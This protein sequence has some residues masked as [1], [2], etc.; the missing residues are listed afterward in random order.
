MS[1]IGTLT[2]IK[3]CKI[4]GDKDEFF[5]QKSENV[6]C[7]LKHFT[8]DISKKHEFVRVEPLDDAEMFWEPYMIFYNVKPLE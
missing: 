4:N 5:R 3:G 2:C 7:C 1:K 8:K 6:F